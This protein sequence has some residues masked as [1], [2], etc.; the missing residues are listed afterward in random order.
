M[1]TIRPSRADR[2]TRTS[3]RSTQIAL[4]LVFV[5]VVVVFA[6]ACGDAD[7][8]ELTDPGLTTST[9]AEGGA[10]EGG[11]DAPSPSAGGVIV[12]PADTG[13]LT[14]FEL[15][16][17]TL[18]YDAGYWTVEPFGDM[19]DPESALVWFVSLDSSAV[20]R[21]S[22]DNDRAPDPSNDPCGAGYGG[23]SDPSRHEV[24]LLHEE[25]LDSGGRLRIH[26]Q[27]LDV[28]SEDPVVGISYAFV[29]FG[30]TDDHQVGDTYCNWE[31]YLD[32]SDYVRD[33]GTPVLYG[34][35]AFFTFSTDFVF[36][37]FKEQFDSADEMRMRAGFAQM[38]ALMETIDVVGTPA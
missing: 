31:R 13:P 26:R 30:T 35:E 37:P 34:V 24:T 20:V 29:D 12:E 4:A 3:T 7:L 36:A 21:V 6:A 38:L 23:D 27:D 16:G 22:F 18:Q 33:D 11:V 5:A 28:A 15:G 8:N 2:P 14:D 32:D 19:E 1:H 9:P 10:G 17:L 25:Q